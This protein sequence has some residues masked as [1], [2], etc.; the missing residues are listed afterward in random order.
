M[1][2]VQTDFR[3]TLYYFGCYQQAGHYVHAPGMRSV[4]DV[5]GNRFRFREDRTDAGTWPQQVQCAC[6][7]A[8]V[9]NVS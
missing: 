3:A 6:H 1:P 9:P 8:T 7:S 2:D 5:G 4:W